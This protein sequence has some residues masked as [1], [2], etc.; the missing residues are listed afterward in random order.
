MRH[1]FQIAAVAAI[2]PIAALAPPAHA[3]LQIFASV[4]PGASP[5]LTCA[6]PSGG[7]CVYGG[8]ANNVL[9]FTPVPFFYNGVVVNGDI[10]TAG[11]VPG[12]PGIDSLDV[13]S[14]ALINTTSAPVTVILVA[15]DTDFTA[16]VS[17]VG[18]ATSGTFQATVG[19]TYTVKW[20][21][22]P[23]N[24]QGADTSGSTPGT[25]LDSFTTTATGIVQSF[26]DNST[27]PFTATAPF[28]LTEEVIY[29][30]Q[31][32]GELLNRGVGMV[33]TSVP[34]PSTWAM[35]ALGFAGLGF[36]G[37]RSS[38]TKISVID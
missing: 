29:T 14:L 17:E 24:T 20:F 3:S 23:S 21:A 34:E 36:M 11:G 35:M 2:F 33:L 12:A 8:A 31:P 5:P 28:S 38:R 18:L 9:T 19:S 16:P 1:S 13:S 22:D 4:V 27:Q 6:P 30:L 32:N 15:S 26:S 10:F 37:Y 7:S 25:L